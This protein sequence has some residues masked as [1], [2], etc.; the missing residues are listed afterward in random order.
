MPLNPGRC[1]R[2]Y[3]ATLAEAEWVAACWKDPAGVLASLNGPFLQP[4]VVILPQIDKEAVH[5]LQQRCQTHFSLVRQNWPTMREQVRQILEEDPCLTRNAKSYRPDRIPVLLEAMDRLA[6]QSEFSWDLEDGLHLLSASTMADNIF[7]RCS[8]VPSHPF[9]D[10][11]ADF[12]SSHEQL[13]HNA[14]IQLMLDARSFLFTELKKRK[15]ESAVLFFDDLLTNLDAALTKS[16]STLA[17]K[18]RSRFPTALVDEFQDT[19]PLQYRIFKT[20]YNQDGNLF[21]IGDP[22]QAIYSFRGADIFTYIQARNHTPKR[23]TYTL[24]TNFRSTTPMVEAINTIFNQERAFIFEPQIQFEPVRAS[25]LVDNTPL[26]LDNVPI[27]PLQGL[28]LGKPDGGSTGKVLNKG[29]AHDNAA[30]ICAL[31]IKKLLTKGSK[32][33]A[34]IGTKHVVAGDIAVLVRTHREAE[35]IQQTLRRQNISS[36]YSSR[37]SVFLSP[38]A[39]EMLRVLPGLATPGA[40]D[41]V[42]NA[43]ASVFFGLNG[44]DL[45]RLHDD[46]TTWEYTLTTIHTLRD[47]WLQ[48]GFMPMFQQLIAKGRLV[49]RLS[50][51]LNGERALTNIL[52]LAELLQEAS[53]RQHGPQELIHWLQQQ[54]AYPDENNSA[55]QLRLESDEELVKIVT[56]H[57]A[58]GLQYPIVFLPFLWS[59]RT[60]QAKEYISF[61]D[62]NSR[63]MIVD[64]SPEPNRD[65]QELAQQER[66]AE[67]LRLLYVALTRACCCCYFCW[68]HIKLME[69]TALAWLLH[70]SPDGS[71]TIAN[72]AELQQQLLKLNRRQ[73]LLKLHTLHE[74]IGPIFLQERKQDTPLAVTRFTGSV[75]YNWQITSYSRLA[76]G[77]D[78]RPENHDVDREF[79]PVLPSREG[80]TP[81]H[82]PRGAAAG[83]CLHAILE[84]IDFTD[85]PT[86]LWVPIIQEQLQRAGIDGEWIPMVNDWL[87]NIVGTDMGPCRL[88]DIAQ[89]DKLNEMGFYF[90][91]RDLDFSRLNT[92]LQLYEIPPLPT[93]SERLTGLMK[94][95]IDLIFRYRGTYYIVDYKSNYLGPTTADYEPGQ[96]APAM[97]EHR[98]DLQ[99][100]IY[101]LALHRYLQRRLPGYSYDDHFGGVFYLFLRGMHPQHPAATGIFRDKPDL[102][103]ITG[104]DKCCG[105]PMKASA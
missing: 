33:E 71:V 12:L 6:V 32:S 46:E 9:F 34:C 64:L 73:S 62:P 72:E 54:I 57:K 104:I 101:T 16:G 2:F 50:A 99:Y 19:D 40:S 87:A 79:R 26:T 42:R 90:P 95:F 1:L 44:P 55:Q 37:D 30:D 47:I 100:L 97:V 78:P 38:E 3:N 10:L 53:T 75:E 25:G 5:D 7:K 43:M 11:F 102:E 77:H 65:H 82:F 89:K 23:N 94:G 15:E 69:N 51:D 20:I 84:L 13:I 98:Y 81:F 67:E 24:S 74:T 70:R 60:P 48:K 49:R 96:L 103:L 29:V 93:S 63:Q 52:H 58:K 68:G 22:K 105:L 18:I 35:V 91:L 56:I 21:M 66:L 83:T 41:L 45:A 85:A 39:D 76:A 92:L 59:T 31:H 88:Q 8:T 14:R 28:W 17:G 61:H 27:L 36:V 86:E 4:E 80:W